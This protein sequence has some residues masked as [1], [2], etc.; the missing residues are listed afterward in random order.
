MTSLLKL[1]VVRCRISAGSHLLTS[2]L[3]VSNVRTFT[4]MWTTKTVIGPMSANTDPTSIFNPLK[5]DTL[6]PVTHTHTQ[7]E[8]VSPAFLMPYISCRKLCVSEVRR[9]RTLASS[10]LSRDAGSLAVFGLKDFTSPE[11]VGGIR[12]ITEMVKDNSWPPENTFL[13]QNKWMISCNCPFIVSSFF[14]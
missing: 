14:I 5:A 9:A 13:K 2:H 8:S 4:G 1:H 6:C 11:T 10:H 12:S 7:R 3:S